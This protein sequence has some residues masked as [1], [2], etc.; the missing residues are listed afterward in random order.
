[1]SGDDAAGRCRMLAIAGG[2]VDGPTCLRRSRH[3]ADLLLVGIAMRASS[4]AAQLTRMIF[5][6]ADRAC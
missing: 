5:G 2:E 6:E 4:S 1:M 3:A